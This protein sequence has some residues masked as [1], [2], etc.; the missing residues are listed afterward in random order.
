MSTVLQFHKVAVIKKLQT[1]NTGQTLSGV[2]SGKMVCKVRSAFTFGEVFTAMVEKIP[3]E[4]H[5]N[6][7]PAFGDLVC[8]V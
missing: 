4:I 3:I 5:Y 7:L 8:C 1:P 6:P 2:W